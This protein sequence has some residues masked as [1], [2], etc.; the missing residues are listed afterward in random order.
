MKNILDTKTIT[1][2]EL[3]GNG[4]KYKIPEFQRDFSWT[5]ENWEDLWQDIIDIYEKKEPVHY[6]GAIVL[7]NTNDKKTF[8]VVD[9]QQRITTLSLF[10]LRVSLLL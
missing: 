6:M 3:L 1:F 4:K 2:Q 5:E 9:G 8:I 7:Q 10:S